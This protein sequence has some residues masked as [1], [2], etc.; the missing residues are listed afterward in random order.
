MGFQAYGD[1][2]GNSKLELKKLKSKL[3]EEVSDDNNHEV[4]LYGS[5]SNIHLST[6]Y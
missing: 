1:A 6:G 5:I 4:G 3:W 2:N